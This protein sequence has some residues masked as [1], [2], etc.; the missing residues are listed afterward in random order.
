[1]EFVDPHEATELTFGLVSV[2]LVERGTSAL[3]LERRL[4][5]FEGVNTRLLWWLH[6]QGLPEL[7]SDALFGSPELIREMPV[8][9]A[10]DV[11]QQLTQK[12]GYSE[13][14][15]NIPRFLP[16]RKSVAGEVEVQVVAK[17]VHAEVRGAFR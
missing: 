16:L 15:G 12:C 13:L 1:V 17:V 3:F 2:A 8:S 4:Q 7:A 11:F 14:D 10:L 9:P 5:G 6:F